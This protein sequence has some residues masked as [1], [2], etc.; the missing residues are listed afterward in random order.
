MQRVAKL[1]AQ[2]GMCSRREAERLIA[3]GQVLV[4]GELRRETGVQAA[5]DVDIRL[6]DIGREW[7]AGLLTVLLNKPAGVVSTQPEGRQRP[8]WQLLTPEN[9][10]GSPDP[11][12][13]E[14]VCAKPYQFAVAGRLDRASRGL[15]VMTQN[16]VLARRITGG[17][18]LRK[19]YVVTFSRSVPEA[20]IT[21]LR[22]RFTLDGKQ[23]KPMRVE[24]VDARR[25]RFWLVEGRKHQIRRCSEEAGLE[26]DDLLREAVGPWTLDGLPPGCWRVLGEDEIA[27]LDRKPEPRSK[28]GRGT[29]SG[30]TGPGDGRSKD[31]RR[32]P[33]GKRQGAR[34]KRRPG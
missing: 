15:L 4:D 3:A 28:G 32:L 2:R 31:K 16:G 34:R 26:I 24:R 27:A 17:G 12:L 18:E 23:L 25:L 9:F 20:A 10:H 22:G 7:M 11:E 5:V 33:D 29:R 14:R 21:R 30:E 13:L 8:A 6:A 19:R 1:M